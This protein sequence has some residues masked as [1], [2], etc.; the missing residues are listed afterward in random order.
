MAQPSHRERAKARRR[1]TIE[2]AAL[3]LFADQGYE[4][5]TIPQIAD[6]ADV[7]PRTVSLYFP[8]KTDLVMDAVD[9]S[10]ERLA[11]MLSK[12]SR[13]ASLVEIFGAWLESEYRRTDPELR[14]MRAL[15]F[16]ANPALRALKSVQTEHV[17]QLAMRALADQ[18][19]VPEEHSAVRIAVAAAVGVLDEYARIG[20][21][22]DDTRG[23][24]DAAMTF[25][26]AGL[27]ALASVHSSPRRRSH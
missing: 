17:L 1:A 11:T 22:D 9:E 3:R 15:M 25:L 2:R 23:A 19:G 26:A 27:D 10:A 20:A 13:T 7:A 18:I 6:A 21:F 16:E 8:S 5:T 4:A 24:H 12:Q 14:A